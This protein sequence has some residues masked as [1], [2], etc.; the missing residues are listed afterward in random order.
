MSDTNK[1]SF[2][3]FFL[4]MYLMHGMPARVGLVNFFLNQ[5]QKNQ[6]GHN[7]KLSVRE[8][9]FTHDHNNISAVLQIGAISHLMML[10]EDVATIFTAIK[11]ND[12]DYYKYLDGKGDENLG[13]IIGKFYSNVDKLKDDDIRF[14]LG[15]LDPK[16][17]KN[18]TESEKD[19][20]RF[21]IQ[22]NIK[23]MRYFLVKSGVFWS[24]HIDVFRRY[25]HAGFPMV[26]GMPIS[27]NDSVSGT[28]FDFKTLVFTA[29]KNPMGEITV[30]PFSNKA[31]KSYQVFL[32]ELSLVL[33]HALK[34]KLIKLERKIDGTIPNELFG[35][36]LTK[37]ER[38]RLD[39]IHSN[40]LKSTMPKESVFPAQAAFKEFYP[41]W[42]F[43]LDTYEKSSMDLTT[44][45]KSNK[46]KQV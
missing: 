32:E 42:Y 34:N 10:I 39:L 3:S 21:I 40:F 6:R 45:K 11:N 28:K 33:R 4:Q 15:Y 2:K 35:E 14:M 27:K 24:S 44:E 38:K 41:A 37:K 5:L 29:K 31:I 1:Y 43:H 13:S 19:F 36:L 17:L 22:K 26:M 30:I 23:L 16:N 9:K 18:S 7:L 8:E 20:L 12:L 25:K 46:S